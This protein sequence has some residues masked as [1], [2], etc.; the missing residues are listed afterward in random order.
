[1]KVVIVGGGIM[2]LATAW[3]LARDGREVELFEQGAVPNPLASSMDE[4]RLIRR[5][6]ENAVKTLLSC[7]QRRTQRRAKR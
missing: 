7:D 3:A 6:A 1:M 2:G 5:C 4:H